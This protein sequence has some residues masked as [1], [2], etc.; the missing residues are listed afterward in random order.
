MLCIYIR[1]APVKTRGTWL[2]NQI[3]VFNSDI[4]NQYDGELTINSPLSHADNLILSYIASKRNGPSSYFTTGGDSVTV[5]IGLRCRDGGV[6][7]CD[8]Q[9]TR[10]NYF[11]FWPK[12]SLLENRFV[13]LSAGNPTIGEAF[14]RRLNAA[15][16]EAAT[17][18]ESPVDRPKAS[19]LI[20]DVLV[21]LAKEAGEDAVKG[22]QLLIA[23]VTDDSELCLWA[24]DADEIYVRE[25]RTWECYGSGIDAAEML[26]KDFYFPEVSSTEAVPLLAYVIRAVGE[27]CLDCGGPV[28]IVVATDQ[29]VRQLPAQEVEAALGKV[30]DPL[31]RMRK[32]LPKRLLKGEPME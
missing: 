28:S 32:V 18:N 24:V 31:D 14:A 21:N 29:G 3:H 23:G 19:Q 6:L 22:R 20:E 13:V 7:A 11:R 26:M 1:R 9:E 5:L 17:V 25:M 16:R 27:I 4:T 30:K 15:F 12:V 2:N 10:V 8:S